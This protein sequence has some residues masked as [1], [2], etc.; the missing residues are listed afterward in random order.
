MKLKLKGMET[1]Y[2]GHGI[3]WFVTNKHEK[4]RRVAERL[5]G[6]KCSVEYKKSK[7]RSIVKIYS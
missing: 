4:A 6:R 2:N 3:E 5:A 7:S 1:N